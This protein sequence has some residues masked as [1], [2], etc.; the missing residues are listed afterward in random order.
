MPNTQRFVAACV[1]D[2]GH[3]IILTAESAGAF[4]RYMERGHQLA[5]AF[6]NFNDTNLGTADWSL[7]TKTYIFARAVAAKLKEETHNEN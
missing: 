7:R 3:K 4:V 5:F 1:L 2:N 6:C